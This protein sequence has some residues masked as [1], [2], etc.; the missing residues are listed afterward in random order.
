MKVEEEVVLGEVEGRTV[1]GWVERDGL[2]LRGPIPLTWLHEIP[3]AN[4]STILV[5]LAL[6]TF[7][8]WNRKRDRQDPEGLMVN[9]ATVMR[10][11]GI[12]RQTVYKALTVLEQAGLIRVTRRSGRAARVKLLVTTIHPRAKRERTA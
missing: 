6:W 8:G 11:W 5:A 3:R 10:L 9:A 7:R 4:P 12:S 2:Y 1:Y